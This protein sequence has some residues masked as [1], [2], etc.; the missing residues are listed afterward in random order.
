MQKVV[1][2]PNHIAHGHAVV[3]MLHNIEEVEEVEHEINNEVS[4]EMTTN[5]VSAEMT[6]KHED[7][8]C[9][10]DALIFT[11]PD[12]NSLIDQFNTSSKTAGIPRTWISLDSQSTINVFCNGEPLT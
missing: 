4:A 12:V 8:C 3:E 7:P 6:T 5:K 10:G 9:H 2:E 1:E 11:Q